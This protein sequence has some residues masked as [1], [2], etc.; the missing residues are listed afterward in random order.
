MHTNA[1]ILNQT[2]HNTAQ[3]PEHYIFCSFLYYPLI[4]VTNS[5]LTLASQTSKPLNN[6]ITADARLIIHTCP[7][8]IQQN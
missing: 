7:A 5:N 4:W 8:T 6:V 1:M 3:R 2:V